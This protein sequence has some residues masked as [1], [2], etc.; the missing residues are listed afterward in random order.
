MEYVKIN[1]NGEIE[2]PSELL[3]RA[4]IEPGDEVIVSEREKGFTVH[5]R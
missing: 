1:H 2:F 5:S 3:N 4:G